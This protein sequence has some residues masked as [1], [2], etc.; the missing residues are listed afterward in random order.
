MA[1]FCKSSCCLKGTKSHLVTWGMT[2]LAAQ[3]PR[4]DVHQCMPFCV[5]RWWEITFFPPFKQA[6]ILFRGWLTD[7]RENGHKRFWR[8][9]NKETYQKNPSMSRSLFSAETGVLCLGKCSSLTHNL[10]TLVFRVHYHHYKWQS[11]GNGSRL[12]LRCHNFIQKL[13]NFM[14]LMQFPSKPNQAPADYSL[15]CTLLQASVISFE[16]KE[17]NILLSS[18]NFL[19]L[20]QAYVARIATFQSLSSYFSPMY[21]LH[22]FFLCPFQCAKSQSLYS[23]QLKMLYWYKYI[24]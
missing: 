5:L 16:S 19:T 6:C 22:F 15:N 21:A 24:L 17:C 7:L 20:C 12:L 14:Y 3:W 9:C 23:V 2:L 11:R 13:M 10:V 1:Y 4:A 8:N 18:V